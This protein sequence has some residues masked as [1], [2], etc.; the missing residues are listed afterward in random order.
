MENTAK[1]YRDGNVEIEN[2]R[3]EA[4]DIFLTLKDTFMGPWTRD[5]AEQVKVA[6]S[7]YNSLMLQRRSVCLFKALMLS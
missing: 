2:P 5:L 1:Q 6:A 4:A 7:T 3:E